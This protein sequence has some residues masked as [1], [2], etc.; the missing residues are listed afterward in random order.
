MKKLK[1][2][3]KEELYSLLEVSGYEKGKIK[4]GLAHVHMLSLKDTGS[5]PAIMINRAKELDC[6]VIGVTDHGYM[7]A[8]FESIEIAQENNMKI[9]AGCECYLEHPITK[10]KMHICLYANGKEGYKALCKVVTKSNLRVEK[11]GTLTYPIVSMELLEEYAKLGVLKAT[12]ACIAGPICSIFEKNDILKQ[13]IDKLVAKA[14]KNPNKKELEKDKEKRDKAEAEIKSYRSQKREL[15]SKLKK[16][17]EKECKVLETEIAKIESTIV[18][19]MEGN[20]KVK[21]KISKA[22]DNL[23]KYNSV[24]GKVEELKANIVSEDDLFMEAVETSL[25]YEELFGKGNFFLEIQNHGMEAEINFMPKIARISKITGIPL[26]AANDVHIATQDEVT[27]RQI[28]RSTR[29][30]DKWEELSDADYELYIKDDYQLAEALAEIIPLEQVLEAMNNVEALLSGC[31]IELSKENH[32]PKYRTENEETAEEA[33]DRLCKKG[34]EWRF[35]N[36]GFDE[37]YQKRLEYELNIIKKMGFVD[38]HLIVH[39]MLDFGRKLGHVPESR[40][41]YLQEHIHDM[42]YEEI[43]KYVEEDQS[44][45][46]YYIGPGRG[47]AA[48]SLVC[49]VLG[50]TS[51]DPIKHDLLFERF[52]NEERVTMPDIDSDIAQEA[53]P[54]LIIFLKKKYGEDALC[55]I[56]ALGYEKARG[57]IRTSGRVKGSKDKQDQKAYNS[58]SDKIA[59]RIPAGVESLEDCKEDLYEEFKDNKDAIEIIDGALIIQGQPKNY[60]MHA[61]GVII[62]DNDDVSDYIPLM[63]DENNHVW[64]SQVDKETVEKVGCL[65]MDLLGLKNLDIITKTIR[66]I[67]KRYGIAIDVDNLPYEQEVYTNI[68]ATGETNAVFQLESNGMKNVNKQFKPNCFDDIIL[69]LAVFRPGPMQYIPKIIQV[70]QGKMQPEYIIPEMKEVLDSTYGYP[71]YQEQLMEIFHKFAG[72]SKGKAD[73]IRRYMS[74][75]KTEKFQQFKVQFIEGMVNRGAD[76]IKTEVF[77]NELVDFSKYAFNKSHAAVYAKISYITAYLKYYYP[78]EYICS[79]LNTYETKTLITKIHNLTSYLTKKGIHLLPPDVNESEAGFS[80]TPQGDMRFGLSCIKGI[81]NS[82]EIVVAKKPY[83]SFRD[84]VQKTSFSKTDVLINAG[85]LDIFNANRQALLYSYSECKKALSKITDKASSLK[86]YEEK[87]TIVQT[88]KSPLTDLVKAGY[89]LKTVP[90]KEILEKRMEVVKNELKE[91]EAEYNHILIPS[92]IKE[93]KAERLEKEKE[94]LGVY[95]SENPLDEYKKPQELGCT[96]IADAT[97]TKNGKIMG[98][99]SN[100]DIKKRKSDG[101]DMAFFQIEDKTGM[102]KVNCFVEAYAKYKDIIADGKVFLIDG[103]INEDE[104]ANDD[105]DEESTKILNITV[106]KITELTPQKPYIVLHVNSIIEWT[107]ITRHLID[108][109]IDNINGSPLLIDDKLENKLR[110][111]NLF[112]SD[113]ILQDTYLQSSLLK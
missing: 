53:R 37:T 30:E 85:A 5:L 59:K 105:N 86:E 21:E 26:V 29:F 11:V 46:G 66:L 4:N 41:K 17:T 99:V 31:E 19:M 113:N 80:I 56:L 106:Y 58:L 67:K 79:V 94:L 98:I 36:G 50:I 95:V 60:T 23:K 107:N 78:A 13:Q 93:T 7:I 39:D 10:K 12:S 112:V 68:M 72:F 65:K 108:D 55:C 63:M 25:Y 87:M 18:K 34:I 35:P 92:G 24:M 6:P 101:S 51:I 83:T 20:K 77:W 9:V 110:R 45:I 16:A 96:P 88:S 103:A 48:G 3:I 111:T 64:K 90:K 54:L 52:L 62:S 44:E 43:V 69:L 32:Y 109:Y 49:F 70:K 84:F 76:P 33:L 27:V 73:I 14:G 15:T 74:K 81:G 61:A 97:V 8:I 42:T 22:E 1:E 102:M 82:C 100:I 89:K 2:E 47:S 75:K 40:F 57:S 91:L 104:F 71:I 38:Y 28:V